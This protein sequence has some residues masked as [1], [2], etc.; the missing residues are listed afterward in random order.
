[1]TRISNLS[2]LWAQLGSESLR[3]LAAPQKRRAVW[4]YTLRFA[5]K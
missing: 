2:I 1:L 4:P 5:V 3:G